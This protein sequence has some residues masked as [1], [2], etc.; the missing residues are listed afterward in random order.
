MIFTMTLALNYFGT[1]L[2]ASALI[3]TSD[4]SEAQNAGLSLAK[5]GDNALIASVSKLECVLS[6]IIL[7]LFKLTFN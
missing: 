5:M 7:Y 4:W 1:M 3:L 2:L 6:S